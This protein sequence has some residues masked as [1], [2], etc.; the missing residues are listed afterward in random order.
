MCRVG[1]AIASVDAN[2]FGAALGF[3]VECGMLL[4]LTTCG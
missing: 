2:L 3:W 1:L 4:A